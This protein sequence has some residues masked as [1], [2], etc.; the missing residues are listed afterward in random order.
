MIADNEYNSQFGYKKGTVLA[1]TKISNFYRH[2]VSFLL[3]IIMTLYLISIPLLRNE[4]LAQ[5]TLQTVPNVYTFNGNGN[6]SKTTNWMGNIKPP[7]LVPKGDSVL[8]QTAPGDSCILDVAQ[9]LADG[10]ILKVVTGSTFFVKNGIVQFV[11]AD[12]SFTDTRDGKVY[13]IK[14]YGNQIWMTLNL[15]YNQARSKVY[16]NDPANAAI[17]G[18]MYNWNQAKAAIPSGWH[19]PSV[20]EWNTLINF[21][22]SGGPMKDTLFW[23]LPNTGASNSSGFSARP[24]GIYSQP[25]FEDIGYFGLWWTSTEYSEL[26]S[27]NWAYYFQ[28]GYNTRG[29]YSD[30]LYKDTYALSVRCVKN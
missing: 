13:P 7:G 16:D 9:Y 3:I 24:G 10:A 5:Q 21:L 14:K 1:F 30:Y 23:Q 2:H 4:L 11:P 29:F 8:I 19:L 17:F 26:G 20:E 6:W 18:R 28:T 15:N 12:S 27:K 22:G 25:E